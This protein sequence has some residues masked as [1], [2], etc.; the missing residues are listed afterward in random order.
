[1]KDLWWVVVVGRSRIIE[2]RVVRVCLFKVLRHRASPL[3][4]ATGSRSYDPYQ[5]RGKISPARVA[6]SIS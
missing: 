6:F 2:V 1:M 5:H 4:K 3:F